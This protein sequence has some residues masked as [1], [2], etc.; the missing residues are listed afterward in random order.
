MPL[1][2]PILPVGRMVKSEDKKDCILLD[3]RTGI[4]RDK[5][6]GMI[7]PMA[8]TSANFLPDIPNLYDVVFW[9]ECRE[10]VM[11]DNHLKVVK[12]HIVL[13]ENHN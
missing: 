3:C 6:P 9:N 13:Q 12:G 10:V 8:N 7:L 4:P 11:Y 1:N 2:L 5:H